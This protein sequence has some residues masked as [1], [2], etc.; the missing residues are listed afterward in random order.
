MTLDFPFKLSLGGIER[1]MIIDRETAK[2]RNVAYLSLRLGF[3]NVQVKAIQHITQ[4][5]AIVTLWQLQRMWVQHGL[6]SSNSQ[7]FFVFRSSHSSFLV[8]IK[9]AAASKK[10]ALLGMICRGTHNC[11]D[12]DSSA[13]CSAQDINN[14]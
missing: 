5:C 4:S 1:E 9:H 7:G 3:D 12:L 13:A 10:A 6:Q 14:S 8:R 11:G 2:K